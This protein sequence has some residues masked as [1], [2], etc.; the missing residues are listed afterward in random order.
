MIH[1]RYGIMDSIRF[2]SA[3]P[4]P[5]YPTSGLIGRYLFN[6]DLTNSYGSAASLES[7]NA[8]PS[9]SY[10]EGKIG[11]AVFF[12]KTSLNE[13]IKSTDSNI[14]NMCSGTN[15]GAV[16]FWI[17]INDSRDVDAGIVSWGANTNSGCRLTVY[18]S[19]SRNIVCGLNNKGTTMTSNTLLTSSST[20]NDNT[21]HHIVYNYDQN[22]LELYID[23]SLVA[24]R[25]DITYNLT[26]SAMFRL[27]GQGTT[28]TRCLNTAT[29]DLLYL[30]NRTLTS[31]E[32]SQ[33]YNSGNGI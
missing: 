5:S 3:P 27:N 26:T 1:T 16:S 21:W 29:V 13:S 15:P 24:N 31:T 25:S 19:S 20:Y 7:Y 33:L 32:V 10:V 12:D 28:T 18:Y 8:T 11:N 2:A 30:Y 4:A 14:L 23:G 6:D 17:K 22:V 9:Y